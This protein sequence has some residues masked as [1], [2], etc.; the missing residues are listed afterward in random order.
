[1]AFGRFIPDVRFTDRVT[2]CGPNDD[3]FRGINFR[4]CRA[5]DMTSLSCVLQE[6]VDAG[7]INEQQAGIY[8]DQAGGLLALLR[9]ENNRGHS[10]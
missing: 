6:M 2:G 3:R 8:K 10:V 9:T 7:I 1:M 4:L 5:L